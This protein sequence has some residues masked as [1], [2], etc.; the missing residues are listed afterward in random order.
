MGRKH[1]FDYFGAFEQHSKLAVAESA[2][3]VETIEQFPEAF[4]LEENTQK[5][6]EIE[7]IG[8]SQGYFQHEYPFIWESLYR[9]RLPPAARYSTASS[10]ACVGRPEKS[11]SPVSSRVR[12]TVKPGWSKAA[13]RS[14]ALYCA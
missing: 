10:W 7:P 4:A 8:D 2:L 1:K 6:H 14:F 3:L 5:A 12:S 13:I 9:M 11:S